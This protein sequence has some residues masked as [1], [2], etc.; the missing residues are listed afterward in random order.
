MNTRISKGREGHEA[1]TIIPMGIKSRVLVIH[2]HKTTGGIVTS[3]SVMTD[4]GNGCLTCI[5][6]GDFSKR[7]AHKGAR[8]TEK[9]VRE[10]HQQALGISDLTMSEAAKFYSQKEELAAA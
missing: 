9:T 2:T 4:M 10:L 7:V 6:F 8:C 1:K 5:L 3:N